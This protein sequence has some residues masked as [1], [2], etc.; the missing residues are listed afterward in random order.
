M[1]ATPKISFCTTCKGRLHHLQQTLPQNLAN[2][3]DYDNV[4]FVILNYDSP[5]NLDSWIREHYA[6]EI[7]SGRIRYARVDD[8]PHF[9]MA[10]AKNLS[11]RLA[12]GDILCNLDADNIIA[13]NSARWMAEQFAQKPDI[14]IRNMWEPIHRRLLQGHLNDKG[15]GGRIAITRDNFNRLHGYDE[16]MPGWEGDDDNLIA[17]A[18]H[19]GLQLIKVPNHLKGCIIAH[20]DETRTE[21]MAP[22]VKERSDAVL[23]KVHS[24][25]EKFRNGAKKLVRRHPIPKPEPD[26]ANPDGRFGEGSVYLNLSDHPTVISSQGSMPPSLPEASTQEGKRRW[27]TTLNPGRDPEEANPPSLR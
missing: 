3:A 22:Q 13:P 19:T 2:T 17:R 7:A 27:V 21:H 6:D 16:N 1:D 18:Q 14:V 23:A 11:H 25:R 4:E 10:H 24:I 8:K 9:H 15:F 26:M 12:T 5:D 20:S